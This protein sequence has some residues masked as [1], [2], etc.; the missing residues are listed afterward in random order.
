MG[1]TPA[2]KAFQTKMIEQFQGINGV[3]IIQDD[4][5]VEGFGN[6]SDQ[7]IN[8]REHICRERNI[9]INLDKCKFLTE[10]VTYM[11]HTLTN[12]GLKPDEEKIRAI[13]E[14]PAPR[15]LHHLRRF[16]GMVKYLSKFDHSL[17]TKCE[18][19]NRLTRKDQIFQWSEVQQRAFEDKESYSK[20]TYLGLLRLRK[21]SH[22]TD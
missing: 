20:H 2:S 7:A 5:L 15:D 10:E 11:G 8:N 6:N 4:C 17:T 16:I 9:K 13:T 14:F 12:T 1:I 21:A 18:P 22:N 19:L 3:S